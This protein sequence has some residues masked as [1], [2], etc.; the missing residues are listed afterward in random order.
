MTQFLS[1]EVS[2]GSGDSV[3]TAKIQTQLE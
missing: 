2:F 1:A 3:R